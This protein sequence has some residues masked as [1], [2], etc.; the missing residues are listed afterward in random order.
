MPPESLISSIESQELEAPPDASNINTKPQ[1]GLYW[2]PEMVETLLTGLVGQIRQGKRPI[3]SFKPAAYKAILP[4][5]QDR[6]TQRGS[7]GGYLQVNV[8]KVRN[9]VSSLKESWNIW[10][11]LVNESGVGRDPDTGAISASD[12]WWEIYLQKVD[13]AVLSCTGRLT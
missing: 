6:V 12:D 3:G 10:N 7:E 13:A 5:I 9:K 2:S 4:A 1:K 8:Q 11:K